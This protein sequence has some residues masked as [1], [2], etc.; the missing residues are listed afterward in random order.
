MKLFTQFQ[1]RYFQLLTADHCVILELSIK[2]INVSPIMLEL[3]CSISLSMFQNWSKYYD[4]ENPLNIGQLVLIINNDLK[5]CGWQNWHYNMYQV[6][7][8]VLCLRN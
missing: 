2:N 4:D 5:Q 1:F 7:I 3:T 8:I 6:L